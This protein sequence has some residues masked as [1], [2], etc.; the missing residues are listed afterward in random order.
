MKRRYQGGM[1]FR[2][3]R[4]HGELREKRRN[5]TCGGVRHGLI[6]GNRTATSG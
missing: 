6:R 1:K 5:K 2:N 4:G 3:S